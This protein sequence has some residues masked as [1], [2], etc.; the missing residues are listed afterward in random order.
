M[1]SAGRRRHDSARA[2][3][4]TTVR[5][6]TLLW[7]YIVVLWYARIQGIADVRHGSGSASVKIVDVD[8]QRTISQGFV[9]D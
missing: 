7:K 3:T 2:D 5:L 9:G 8:R 4:C 6:A 1:M